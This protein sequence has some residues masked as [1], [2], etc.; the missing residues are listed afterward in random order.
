MLRCLF[1]VFLSALSLFL[2]PAIFPQSALA[3][4]IPGVSDL[5]EIQGKLDE[6]DEIF[7]ES[8]ANLI[9]FCERRSGNQIHANAGSESEM[10]AALL[11]QKQQLFQSNGNGIY[12]S[13]ANGIAFLIT[14]P[15]ASTKSY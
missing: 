12:N 13:L 10:R 15:P 6:I 3:I 1:S 14:N 5:Q 4:Y 11:E 8:N 7:K 9:D 2:F